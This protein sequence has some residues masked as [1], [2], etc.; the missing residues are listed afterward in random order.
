MLCLKITTLRAAPTVSKPLSVSFQ[1]LAVAFGFLVCSKQKFQNS[2]QV[3][4]LISLSKC[5]LLSIAF[6]VS[7]LVPIISHF[8]VEL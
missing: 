2:L 8:S 4:F 6:I 7:W 1:S 5:S 3:I